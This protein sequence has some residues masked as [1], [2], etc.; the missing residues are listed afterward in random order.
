M[1]PVVMP[2]NPRPLSILL[3]SDD[4]PFVDKL[5]AAAEER[6]VE[7]HTLAADQDVDVALVRH[8][9]NVYV[10]DA[11]AAVRR[12]ARSATAFAARHPDIPVALVAERTDAPA[13]AGLLLLDKWQPTEGLLRAIELIF[14]SACSTF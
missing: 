2:R 1:A 9:A 3:A 5:T 14:S 11:D 10:V 4:I 8:G 6:G 13:A 7:L 12:G